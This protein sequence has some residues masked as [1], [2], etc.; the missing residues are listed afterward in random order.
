MGLCPLFM[1][2]PL[3][4]ML[5]SPHQVPSCTLDRAVA[6]TARRSTSHGG[7]FR[8]IKS[9]WTHAAPDDG[10]AVRTDSG[11]D[12]RPGRAH[13][14]KAEAFKAPASTRTLGAAAYKYAVGAPVDGDDS[15]APIVYQQPCRKGRVG[16][17]ERNVSRFA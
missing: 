4:G 6:L 14:R 17:Y 10:D 15:L 9:A 13:F 3:H 8:S 16:V 2:G 1:H 11:R 12:R 7:R 5:G